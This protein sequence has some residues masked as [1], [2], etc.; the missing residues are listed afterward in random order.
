MCIVCMPGAHQNQKKWPN[1]LELELQRV[2]S[3][4]IGAENQ[5]HILSKNSALL[6]AES[7]F[8]FPQTAFNFLFLYF[9]FIPFTPITP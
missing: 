7:N 6:I 4:H 9:H 5:T 2:A 3:H 1:T 8:K